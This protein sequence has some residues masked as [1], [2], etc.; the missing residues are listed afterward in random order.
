M[1]RYKLKGYEGELTFP[2]VPFFICG[3]HN[4]SIAT[5]SLSHITTRSLSYIPTRSV[6][7][8]Q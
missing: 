6:S 3:Q 2:L 8:G 4:L 5:R 7:E 1:I